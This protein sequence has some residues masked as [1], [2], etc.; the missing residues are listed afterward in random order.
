M[1]ASFSEHAPE[2]T[3]LIIKI[4]PWDSGMDDWEKYCLSIAKRYDLENRVKYIDGGNLMTL[5][6]NT[7]GTVMVN[8]SVGISAVLAGCPITVLG[9]AV[10]DVPGLTYQAGLE[11]FWV[12]HTPPDPKLCDAYIRALVGTVHVK[13]VYFKEPGLSCAVKESAER[14]TKRLINKPYIKQPTTI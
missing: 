1:I 14:L 6:E 10:F 8:S 9:E 7:A 5:L 12:E 3:L 11:R 4:H 2:D 13:G